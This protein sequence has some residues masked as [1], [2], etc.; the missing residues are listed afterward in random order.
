V[1]HKMPCWKQVRHKY[2][3]VLEQSGSD[4]V[5]GLR[6]R[7]L[8]ARLHLRGDSNHKS[9]FTRSLHV[10]TWRLVSYKL[11]GSGHISQMMVQNEA[12]GL[13]SGCENLSTFSDGDT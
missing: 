3:G 9:L 6:K 11:R 4:R 2:G 10:A 12:M 13:I 5:G 1:L 7:F 8:R